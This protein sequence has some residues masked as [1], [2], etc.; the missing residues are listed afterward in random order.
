VLWD[1]TK[2]RLN[3]VKHGVTFAEAQSVLVDALAS[4]TADPN[5]SSTEDRLRVTGMSDRR[6][7][8]VVVVAEVDDDTVRLISAWRPSRRERH[9]YQDRRC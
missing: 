3:R 8:L 6:R 5:H 7:L 4:V 1:D 2:D 9:E